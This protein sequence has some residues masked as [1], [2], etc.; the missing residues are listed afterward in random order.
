MY[1]FESFAPFSSSASDLVDFGGDWCSIK[2]PLLLHERCVL[3]QGFGVLF[4]VACDQFSVLILSTG[5]PAKSL[6]LDPCRNDT[7]ELCF[8]IHFDLALASR[9]IMNW[10]K[11]YAAKVNPH[12]NRTFRLWPL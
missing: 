8:Q 4:K 10:F 6:C 9:I 11:L 7:A 2:V 12:P 3:R 1:R 5:G